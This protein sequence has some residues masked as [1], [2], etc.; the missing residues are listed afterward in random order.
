MSLGH[1]KTDFTLETGAPVEATRCLAGPT[2][3]KPSHAEGEA[4]WR[5]INHLSLNYLSLADSDERSGAEALRELLSLYGQTSEEHVRKQIDG[6]RSVAARPITRRMPSPGPITF[7][8]GLE[9]T[10]TCDEHE[11]EGTGVFMLGAVM[12]QFFAK[13][14]SINSFTETVVRTLDRGEVIRWPLRTGLHPTL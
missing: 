13:Y 7:G 4:A 3:P 9:V 12:E 14:V 10:L 11:F 2:K 6:V 8:R 1:G 5:L